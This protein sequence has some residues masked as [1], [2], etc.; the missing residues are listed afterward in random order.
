MKFIKITKAYPKASKMLHTEDFFRYP[1]VIAKELGLKPEIWVVK[2]KNLP[3]KE[4]V[5]GIKVRRFSNS[6]SLFFHLFSKDIKLI[7]SFLRPVKPS[8][9][10]GLINK[11]KV[12]TTC[13]YEVGSTKLIKAISLFF[14]KKFYKIICLTPYELEIYKKNGIDPKK[15]ILLPFA[16][17]YPFFSKRLHNKKAIIKK[18]GIAEGDFKIITVANFRAFKNLDIMMEAFKIFNKKMP[19]STFI[20][21]GQDLLKANKLYKEQQKS[22]ETINSLIKGMEKIKWVGEKNPY[23]IRG[24]LNMSDVYVSSSSI[25]AQ[26][27]TNYEASATGIAICLSNIGSF[28]TVFKDFVLYHDPQDYKKLANNFIRYYKN[29][30]LRKRN[31]SKV[32][33]LVKKWD[34]P[35]IKRKLKKLYIETLKKA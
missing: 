23:E 17:D 35:I 7:H 6:L 21:V 29:K 22:N 5:D 19:K 8:L 20:V 31:G 30:N 16:V 4:I 15:L 13:S 18:Y 2:R 32:K 10:A 27:V 12:F 11:P 9:L 24:L 26:G 25:E 14:L 28:K 3:K 1:C 33:K 34:Y